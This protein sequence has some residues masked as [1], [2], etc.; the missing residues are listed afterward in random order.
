METIEYLQVWIEDSFE[1]K[2]YAKPKRLK[3]LNELSW[4][5]TR[6]CWLYFMQIFKDKFYIGFNSFTS[7]AVQWI[8]IHKYLHKNRIHGSRIM[9][10][11]EAKRLKKY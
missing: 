6:E 8:N 5:A 10:M 11:A 7:H 4:V 1:C 3:W 2:S 9:Y